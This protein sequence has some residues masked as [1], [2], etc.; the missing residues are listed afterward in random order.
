MEGF[1]ERKQ[2]KALQLGT[3]NGCGSSFWSNHTW[4]KASGPKSHLSL[5]WFSIWT[6]IIINGFIYIYVIC[7]S[8][9]WL[10][11][12]LKNISQL[13]LFFPI[14]GRI[15]RVPNH[16]P[17]LYDIN[18]TFD[19]PAKS[20]HCFPRHGRYVSHP[21]LI[22]WQILI[23]ALQQ[24]SWRSKKYPRNMNFKMLHILPYIYILTYIDYRYDIHIGCIV[25]LCVYIYM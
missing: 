10:Q 11:P 1:T 9:W 22:S 16:Q 18:G 25:L 13:G 23:R 24:R 21:M 14:Y 6:S 8:G 19:Q 12:R 15:K 2:K 20:K 3:S 17:D 5:A 7:I 4:A